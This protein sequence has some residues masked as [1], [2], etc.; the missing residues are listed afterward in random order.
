MKEHFVILCTN[1]NEAKE[2]NN[3]LIKRTDLVCVD[4]IIADNTNNADID[5]AFKTIEN[6]D[7]IL[8]ICEKP[9]SVVALLLGFAYAKNKKLSM[10]LTTKRP[11]NLMLAASANKVY[12]TIDDFANNKICDL[13]SYKVF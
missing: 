1:E 3:A 8:A 13:M 12:E 7:K 6:A 5:K 11:F 4:T 2:I 10:I 9:D